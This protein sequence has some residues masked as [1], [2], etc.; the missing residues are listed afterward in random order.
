MG[1]IKGMTLEIYSN[2]RGNSQGALFLAAFEA[3]GDGT[4]ASNSCFCIS[5]H[6]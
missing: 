3:K 2:Y 6:S 1:F 5:I 4:L